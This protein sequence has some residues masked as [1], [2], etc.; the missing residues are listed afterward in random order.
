MSDPNRTGHGTD[1]HDVPGQL[2]HYGITAMYTTEADADTSGVATG[3]DALEHYLADG[4]K[5]I[6]SVNAELIWG[7]R[8]KTKDDT[9]NPLSG[10]AVVVTGVDTANG[11]VHLNDSGTPDGKDGTVSIALF[12]KSWA[13]SDAGSRWPGESHGNQTQ[14]GTRARYC[15]IAKAA[16][17]QPTA[18]STSTTSQCRSSW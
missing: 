4:H 17:T 16:S 9:G 10:H 13:T 7:E 14:Y 1:A 18:V 5:V 8:V 6:V 3:M 11:K 12:T 2:A 15:R